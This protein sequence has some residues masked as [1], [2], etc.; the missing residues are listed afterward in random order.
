[1]ISV[2][3]LPFL[4]RNKLPAGVD[5]AVTALVTYLRDIYY[6]VSDASF[7]SD[8]TQRYLDERERQSKTD[9]WTQKGIAHK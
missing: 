7:A 1:M 9:E 3:L 8:A 5:T 6:M 4:L 2:G